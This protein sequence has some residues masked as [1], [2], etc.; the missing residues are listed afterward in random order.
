MELTEKKNDKYTLICISGRLDTMT[1]ATLERKLNEIIEAG[2][3]N[4][5]IDCTEMDYVSSSGLR[6]FLL[7]MKKVSLSQGKF[8]LCALKENIMD[9]FRI[10]GFINIFEVYAS[11]EEAVKIF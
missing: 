5:L 1:Y 8:V 4:I 10:S 6:V 2:R 9:I 7:A 3:N 11:R